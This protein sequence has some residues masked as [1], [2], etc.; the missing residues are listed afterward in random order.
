MNTLKL[1]LNLNDIVDDMFCDAEVCEFGG[2][3]P[4]QSFSEAVRSTVISDVSRG[5]IG[6]LSEASKKKASDMAEE[7]T[8]KF[9]ESELSGI[10]SRK[11]RTGELLVGRTI[12]KS[13]DDLIT[14]RISSFDV[15]KVIRDHIDKKTN[16]FAKE[17]LL[18]QQQLKRIL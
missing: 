16:D 15:D 13:L 17:M 12:F 10:V 6:Q 9:I 8:V 11:L 2:V 4:S 5:L 3:S 1:E 18:H 7:V 14:Y